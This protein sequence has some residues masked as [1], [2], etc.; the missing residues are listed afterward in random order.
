MFVVSLW[1]RSPGINCRFSNNQNVGRAFIQNRKVNYSPS[2]FLPLLEIE[3]ITPFLSLISI[4]FSLYFL[5]LS[6]YLLSFSLILINL[7]KYFLSNTALFFICF[8]VFLSISN[9]LNTFISLSFVCFI[10]DNIYFSNFLSIS[11]FSISY[12]NVY[13]FI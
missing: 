11:L 9:C 2:M 4:C 5:Y 7:F 12:I 13:S 6:L 10:F 3:F 1:I 8:F